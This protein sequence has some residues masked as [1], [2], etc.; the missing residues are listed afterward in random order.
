M[1][2]NQSPD[3]PSLSTKSQTEPCQFRLSVKCINPT[4]QEFQI[5]VSKKL[6]SQEKAETGYLRASFTK[7]EPP[8]G[9]SLFAPFRPH[10][11]RSTQNDTNETV[12]LAWAIPDFGILKVSRDGS[13]FFD[14]PEAESCLIDHELVLKTSG[15]L[16]IQT[17]KVSH[18]VL[19]SSETQMCGAIVTHQLHMDHNVINEAGLSVHEITGKGH[20]INHGLIKFDGTKEQPGILGV[21]QVTNEKNSHLPIEA[22]I[23]GPYLRINDTTQTFLNNKAAQV[24]ISEKLTLESVAT[25]STPLLNKGSMILNF[26]NVSRP[27]VNSGFCQVNYLLITGSASPFTNTTWGEL[28]SLSRLTIFSPLINQGEIT[29]KSAINLA[30]GHNT[31]KIS[32]ENLE[33]NISDEFVNDGEIQ[34]DQLSGDGKLRNHRDLIIKGSKVH[35]IQGLTNE[36]TSQHPAKIM[37]GRLQLTRGLL[38]NATKS[39]IILT[40]DLSLEA[41]A[42]T[43]SLEPSRNA[44]TIKV[45]SLTLRSRPLE[46]SGRL[47][48]SAGSVTTSKLHNLATGTL[49][50]NGPLTLIDSTLQNDGELITRGKFSQNAGDV[51]NSGHW[52][53]EGDLDLGTTILRNGSG[54]IKTMISW[55]NGTVTSTHR[56]HY[57]Q[58]TWQFD[59]IR[60]SQPLTIHNYTHLY[61]RNSTMIFNHIVNHGLVAL[62][63]GQYRINVGLQNNGYLRFQ[64]NNWTLS[65]NPANMDPHHLIL[66]GGYGPTGSIESQKQLI[67]DLK[68]LPKVLQ[69]QGDIIFAHRYPRSLADLQTVTS[70]GTIALWISASVLTSCLQATP[71][72]E[73]AK[74]GHLD[75]HV[76][77]ALSIN[78][79]IKAPSLSLTVNGPL[80]VGSSN[81]TLGTIAATTGPLTLIAQ[82]IDGRFGKIYGAGL[83]TLQSTK[84]DIT[85]GAAVRGVDEEIKRGYSGGMS[86]IAQYY[87]TASPSQFDFTFNVRNGSYLASNNKLCLKSA[88]NIVINFGT[89]SSVEGINLAGTDIRNTSGKIS[90]HGMILIKGNKYTQLRDPTQSKPF[91]REIYSATYDYPGSGPAILESLG[92]VEFDVK[93]VQNIAGSIRSGGSLILNK[94]SYKEEALQYHYRYYTAQGFYTWVGWITPVLLTQSCILQ[95]GDKISMNLGGFTITGSMSAPVITIQATGSGIFNNSSQSRSTRAVNQPV[96]VDLT[97]YL[98]NQAKSP[99]LL[100]LAPNGEVGTEFPLGEPSRPHPN[101]L[102]AYDRAP[103]ASISLASIFNPLSSINLDLH[104]QSVLADVA[105]KVY[106]KT[107]KGK[108]LA[109]TLWGN[110]RRW[111][112]KTSKAV[113]DSTDLQNISEALLLCQLQQVGTK[114]QQQTLLCLPPSEINHYQDPGDIVAETFT[115]M[116]GGDQTHQN[117]RI[118]TQGDLN[119]T[120]TQGRVQLETQFYTVFHHDGERKVTQDISMPQQQL[121]SQQG[122]IAVVAHQ[123]LT[124]M[125]TQMQAHGN[126]NETST[127]GSIKK[128][129]LILRKIV[130]T[131]HEE[132]D[133][134]FGTTETVETSLTHSAVASTTVSGSTLREKAATEIHHTGTHDAATVEIQY[135]APKVHIESLLLANRTETTAETSSA[136]SSQTSS[137]LQETAFAE[138]ATITAPTVRFVGTSA[139]VAGAQIQATT[140]ENATTE[141]I[142]FL[143]KVIELLSSQR[144]TSESPL[145]TVDACFMAGHETMVPTMLLVE[146]VVRTQDTGKMILESVVW[147]RDRTHIIGPFVETTYQLKHWQTSWCRVEQVIPDEALMVV[148]LA[149]AIATQGVG[150]KALAPMLQGVT[151]AT[152][153]TL[154]TAGVAMVNAGFTTLCSTAA[155]S[156]LRTGD[157]GQV[158]KELISPTHLKSMVFNMA[159]AGLCSKLGQLLELDLRPG[160]KPLL[161]HAKEQALRGTVDTLLTLSLTDTPV[162]VAITK[163]MTHIPI[164]AVAAYAANQISLAYLNGELDSISHKFAH[165]V[166]G[167]ISGLSYDPSTRG[168]LAGATGAITAELVGDLLM[169]E[170]SGVADAAITKLKSTNQPVTLE[171]IPAAI[172]EEVHRRTDLA[173]LVAGGVAVLTKQDPAIAIATATN[174]TDN[175]LTVRA[176]LYAMSEVL[177][178]LTAASQAIATLSGAPPVST[179]PAVMDAP[180]K[181]QSESSEP[182]N[183]VFQQALATQPVNPYQAVILEL[184]RETETTSSQ[185]GPKKR[186]LHEMIVTG[187]TPRLSRLVEVTSDIVIQEGK[188]AVNKTLNL[189][190]MLPT[191]YMG[192]CFATTLGRDLYAGQTTVGEILFNAG[193]TL[194]AL[195]VVQWTG[196]GIKALYQSGKQLTLKLVDKFQARRIN[197]IP[198]VEN[199]RAGQWSRATVAEDLTLHDSYA[200]ESAWIAWNR[201]PKGF[202]NVLGHGN[203]WSIEVSSQAIHPRALSQANLQQ[204]RETGKV[205]LNAVQLARAIRTAPGYTKG[206]PINLF[207]CQCGARSNGLAQ[208]LADRMQV[209]VSAF[210]EVVTVH[211][212]GAFWT[213]DQVSQE[214]GM[215]KTFH[216]HSGWG[217]HLIPLTM[218]PAALLV[219]DEPVPV[220]PSHVPSDA[221][222]ADMYQWH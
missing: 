116:T 12:C 177:A 84:Q 118:V 82:S 59:T 204:L 108:H 131:H 92:N 140:V 27:I 106:T 216:P 42:T 96:V 178:V 1:T 49:H 109:T 98:Q 15:K 136:F 195:K 70:S 181:P 114:L 158:T 58:G 176:S 46:N 185:R 202:F 16:F 151:A 207:S 142:K 130:E 111:K 95:S 90:S 88:N 54:N 217:L 8:E 169:S 123:D 189:F 210:T 75:L 175:D 102:V 74:A 43:G 29:A 201:N 167:G 83:T 115:A 117:N 180:E 126:V 11:T 10:F 194:G 186:S 188:E 125:G 41:P 119:I 68:T 67:Y 9:K 208:Q 38:V 121:V 97:Q 110:A 33:I 47:E 212:S 107:G 122:N 105:G 35:S 63:G 71:N 127:V 81:D 89:I 153:M 120:S 209:P 147:D 103:P 6:A 69:S 45:G 165:D 52:D 203:P 113:M 30:S 160:I 26:A 183:D 22:Q 199:P 5:K 161:D 215:L 191:P 137:S 85:L 100:T 23:Q 36:T 143:P 218:I 3:P 187:K 18:L 37:G 172:H 190:S 200:Y 14:Q 154:S 87:C 104:I 78:G 146:R 221:Q 173:K 62:H 32:G 64:D 80:T 55:K 66:T 72:Y 157:L 20:L 21:F 79:S 48:M 174:A 222:L 148:A 24:N 25:N 150:V 13:V 128:N 132:S 220:E 159:S 193:L 129:P 44:G 101:D 2:T 34:V 77:G 91:Y 17:L 99:G 133:G 155:T 19:K 112:E 182:M 139:T 179:E 56:E 53:H 149:V 31:G 141:G 192:A 134:L 206:Q 196:R 73:C 144:Y 214:Y 28:K 65:D 40:Q 184:A 211:E 164:K 7:L 94:E 170:A 213:F 152:G 156:F 198:F 86:G 163:N 124:R 60:C 50:V 205:A 57:N 4:T 61:L 171:N 162:N 166:V 138:Q 168:F 76:E 145:R 93:E 51:N 39:S 197:N 219:S 135:Q